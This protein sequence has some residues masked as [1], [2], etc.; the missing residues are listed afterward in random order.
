MKTYAVYLGDHFQ[1]MGTMVECARYL[2]ITPGSLRNIRKHGQDKPY[3]HSYFF[4][5][6]TDALQDD[7]YLNLNANVGCESNNFF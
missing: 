7:P 4:V 2:K 6:V 3:D 1:C 5:D